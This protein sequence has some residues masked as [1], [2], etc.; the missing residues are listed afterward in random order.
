[1]AP[2]TVLGMGI[3]FLGYTLSS[4]GY[5]LVRGYNITLGEWLDPVHA[6]KWPKEPKKVP[7]GHIFPTKKG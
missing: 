3:M 4:W 6:Y 1:M 7:H 2:V 5:V